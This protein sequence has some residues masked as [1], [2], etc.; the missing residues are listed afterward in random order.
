MLPVY[1]TPEGVPRHFLFCMMQKHVLVQNLIDVTDGKIRQNT[2]WLTFKL[3]GNAFLVY[4]E[5]E[6]SFRY[7]KG[8]YARYF[9]VLLSMKS[10]STLSNIV[11]SAC[12]IRFQCNSSTQSFF[13]M[14]LGA[15]S[16]RYH[17][18]YK[19][20]SAARITN[21]FDSHSAFNSLPILPFYL[22]TSTK[23]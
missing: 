20:P 5:Q 1:G 11:S 13:R 8:E 4:F 21:I 16:S 2:C 19:L 12:S 6:T 3:C 14:I 17:S 23:T 9:V 15:E 18:I 22:S 10:L 7:L